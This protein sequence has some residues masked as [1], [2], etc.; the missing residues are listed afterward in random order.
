VPKKCDKGKGDAS[1]CCA[2]Y[3]EE[4]HCLP[5]THLPLAPA[6]VSGTAVATA[7]QYEV[8]GETG[9]TKDESMQC[10]EWAFN[11][12]RGLLL[13]TQEY[14]PIW[15][16]VCQMYLNGPTQWVDHLIGKKHKRSCRPLKKIQRWW[17]RNLLRW[18]ATKVASVT[19]V[20]VDGDCCSV[21][22]CDISGEI[23]CCVDVETHSLSVVHLAN[24]LATHSPALKILDPHALL[25]EAR[26]ANRSVRCAEKSIA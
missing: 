26:L 13:Q 18:H 14:F 11:H 5:Q 9:T 4:P 3:P 20:E 2:P 10:E 15:C 8:V 25:R 22:L 1:S 19:Q 23:V 16:D 12:R 7:G 6:V 17:R 21:T 24:C